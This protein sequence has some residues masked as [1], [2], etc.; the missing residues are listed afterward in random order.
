[1][2]KNATLSTLFSGSSIKLAF[3]TGDHLVF[4]SDGIP[5]WGT[6]QDL[7]PTP[8][9]EVL[10]DGTSCAHRQFT[11]SWSASHVPLNFYDSGSDTSIFDLDTSMQTNGQSP[12]LTYYGTTLGVKFG[13]L[14][15]IRDGLT[16]LDALNFGSPC[17]MATCGEHIG[18]GGGSPHGHADPYGPT[19]LY[20]NNATSY[21]TL[22]SHPPHIGFA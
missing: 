21:P 22:A 11:E 1:M 7:I 15:W 6:N 9:T 18:E 14:G 19:C 2:C 17:V 12:F 3:C 5:S 10:S 13:N 20:Y 4:Y 8:T 16:V